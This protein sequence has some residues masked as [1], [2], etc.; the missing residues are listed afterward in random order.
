MCLLIIFLF[1][2]FLQVSLAEMG[3][4]FPLVQVFQPPTWATAHSFQCKRRARRRQ[5]GVNVCVRPKGVR[6]ISIC[7]L[8]R[9]NTT[10]PLFGIQSRNMW[11]FLALERFVNAASKV[12]VP[13]SIWRA[14]ITIA[15]LL[16]SLSRTTALGR[17]RCDT[18]REDVRS[19]VPTIRIRR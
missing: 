10:Q 9:R 16:H 4:P 3:Q 2:D 1:K 8:S 19:C 7:L 12:A 13:H 5:R 18:V 6:G 15:V 11:P 17:L 14:R